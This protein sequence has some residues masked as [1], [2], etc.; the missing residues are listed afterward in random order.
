MNSPIFI[1]PKIN[2]DSEENVQIIVQFKTK[3]AVIQVKLM[4]NLTMEE[5]RQLVEESHHQFQ[6]DVVTYLDKNQ[7]DYII[8][9]RYKEAYNGVAMKLKGK[10]IKHL[11]QSNEI[12]AIYKS[13]IISIPPKP[14][15][16]RY[17][18]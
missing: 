7:I 8:L 14:N 2:L 1:D 12:G 4:P 10:D 13:Q 5:A 6:Q 3:P 16:P 9:N 15:D 18:I 11:L 17:Q